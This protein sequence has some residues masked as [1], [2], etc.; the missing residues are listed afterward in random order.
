MDRQWV[1]TAYSLAFGSLL[2]LGRPLGIPVRLPGTH[3]VGVGPRLRHHLLV[4]GG[5]LLLARSL[6]GALLR[7]GPLVPMG[8]LSQADR[9]A[10]TPPERTGQLSVETL[11][12]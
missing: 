7:G 6:G 11:K 9:K 8:W 4:D 5:D 12:P 2:L 1:V 3:G 10:P